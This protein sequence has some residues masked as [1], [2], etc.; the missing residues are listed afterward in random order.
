MWL[1]TLYLNTTIKSHYV[2]ITCSSTSSLF[3][4]TGDR[5]EKYVP[6]PTLGFEV[7]LY[8]AYQDESHTP[9]TLVKCSLFCLEFPKQIVLA[10]KGTLI[11]LCTWRGFCWAR[12]SRSSRWGS[13]RVIYAQTVP[14]QMHW[15]CEP[16]TIYYPKALLLDALCGALTRK[17]P[18]FLWASHDCPH[19]RKLQ[20]TQ[21]L[22]IAPHFAWESAPHPSAGDNAETASHHRSY[23]VC[24]GS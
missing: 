19:C 23:N 3:N 5:E 20:G 10:Y 14:L 1:F 17:S 8:F 4:S 7:S 13:D 16:P 15:E 12:L 21:I 22:G 11:G 9:N 2:H 18:P 6:V 24:P